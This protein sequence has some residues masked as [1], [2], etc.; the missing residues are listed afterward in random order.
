MGRSNAEPLIT[1]TLPGALNAQPVEMAIQ[2]LP[3]MH[4][5]SKA[6]HAP[7]NQH[8]EPLNKSHPLNAMHALLM[9]CC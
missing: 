3:T 5:T 6:D 8:R 7:S 2:S 4:T 9:H 1:A